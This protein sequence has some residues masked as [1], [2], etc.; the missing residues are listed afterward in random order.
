MYYGQCESGE[1]R[2][3]KV[4]TGPGRQRKS[5]QSSVLTIFFFLNLLLFPRKLFQSILSLVQ[6][7]FSFVSISLSCYYDTLPYS[8][9]KE[10][11]I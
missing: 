9:T 2:M 8:K 1:Y 7:L 6:I 3:D 11:K 5:S 10:N 4:F